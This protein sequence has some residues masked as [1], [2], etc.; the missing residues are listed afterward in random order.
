MDLKNEHAI[1]SGHQTDEGRLDSR[2]GISLL[3]LWGIEKLTV[4][5][6]LPCRNPVHAKIL[7][8]DTKETSMSEFNKWMIDPDDAV[9]LLIGHQSGLFQLAK[10]IERSELC[11]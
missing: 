8:G 11:E 2:F 3:H 1:N 10:D 5:R 7:C 9:V 4:L 6:W